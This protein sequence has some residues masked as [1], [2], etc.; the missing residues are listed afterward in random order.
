MK[1]TRPEQFSALVKESRIKQGLSQN[2][3]AERVGL[4]IA[5]I[6]NFEN[7]PESCKLDTVFKILAALNIAIE[8]TERNTTP[9]SD[10]KKWAE[11]W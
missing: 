8:V 6:S 1:T 5:T 4:R 9:P 3:V 7:K 11:G 2:D 10:A